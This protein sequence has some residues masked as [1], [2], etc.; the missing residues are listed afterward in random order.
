MQHNNKEIKRLECNVLFT[1]FICVN[2]GPVSHSPHGASVAIWS[3]INRSYLDM[4]REVT[5]WTVTPMIFSPEIMFWFSFLLR[6]AAFCYSLPVPLFNE[7]KGIVLQRADTVFKNN[8]VQHK[9]HLN[10][11]S[12]DHLLCARVSVTLSH[13]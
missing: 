6:K 9:G 11:K 4:E 5:S 7:I 8:L 3:W 2:A 12:A 10:K 1:N 13:I